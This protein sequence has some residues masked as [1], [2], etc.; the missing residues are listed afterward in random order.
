MTEPMSKKEFVEMLKLMSMQAK[1]GCVLAARIPEDV[2]EDDDVDA[3][4]SMCEPIHGK[5]YVDDSDDEPTRERGKTSV[6]LYPVDDIDSW[7][8]GLFEKLSGYI[9]WIE[10]DNRIPLLDVLAATPKE[11]NRV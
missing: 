6:P 3:W 5:L 9:W 11:Q 10:E 2:G 4:A 8:E 1:D 7:P